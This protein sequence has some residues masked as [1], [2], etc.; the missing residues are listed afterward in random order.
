[1]RA[2][3]AGFVIV[4]ALVA[5]PAQA[6]TTTVEST[7][8]VIHAGAVGGEGIVAERSQIVLRQRVTTV[9]AAVLDEPAARPSANGRQR[10]G[11]PAGERLFGIYDGDESWAYCALRASF[12]SGEALTCYQDTDED[13]R[14][15]VAKP[16]GAPFLGVPFFTLTQNAEQRPLTAPAAFRRIP[17]DQGPAIEAGLRLTLTEARVRR[18]RTDPASAVLEFGY[19]LDNNRFVPVQGT[20]LRHEFAGDGPVSLTVADARIELSGPP[21]RGQ[22]RYRVAE[23]MPAQLSRVIMTQTVTYT[24]TYVPIYIPR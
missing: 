4:C 8:V 3:L 22:L 20:S 11:F 10:E 18:T 9:R 5:A 7:P 2:S 13:G 15:D 16:S 21:V 12:W 6:Q 24:T 1:M 23:P 19:I 17:F 14:L